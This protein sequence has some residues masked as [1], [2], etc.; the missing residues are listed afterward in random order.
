MA[1]QR[2]EVELPLLPP[3]LGLPRSSIADNAALRPATRCELAR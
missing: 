3:R 1:R 2:R